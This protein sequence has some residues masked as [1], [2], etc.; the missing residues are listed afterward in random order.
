MK[1]FALLIVGVVVGWA[2]SGVDWSRD[3]YAID[4]EYPQSLD[5]RAGA[6]DSPATPGYGT[7]PAPR[8]SMP[9]EAKPQLVGR[10]LA[11]AYGSPSGHGCYVVDTMTGQTWHVA[12]GQQP[13]V[14]VAGLTP[15]AP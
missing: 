2:A 14:V 9:Q 15:A 10:F 5:L 11:S 6:F 3:A 7:S 12:N 8:L 13:Q 4:A 1:P